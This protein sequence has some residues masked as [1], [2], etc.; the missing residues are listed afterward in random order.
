MWKAAL[1]G[2]VALATIG[3]FS[4]APNGVGITPAAAQDVVISEAQIAQLKSA[5]RLTAAQEHHWRPVEAR[6]RAL[7]RQQDKAEGG[8]V[9]RVRAS[10]SGYALSAVALARLKSAAQ[11]LIRA[12]DDEQK[13]AG[14]SA[15]QSMGV[16]F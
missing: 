15:L 13:Q 7:G 10:V 1:A 4:F 16:M 14:L 5:L 3:S 9:E 12:L 8:M 6:L 11:P 2:A